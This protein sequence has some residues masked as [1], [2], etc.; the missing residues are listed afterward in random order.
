MVSEQQHVV[1]AARKYLIACRTRG[2]FKTKAAVA[3]DGDLLVSQRDTEAPAIVGA[4]TGPVIGIRRQ[5]MMNVYRLQALAQVELGQD[6][7]EDDRVAATRKADC[8]PPVSCCAGREKGGDPIGNLIW[9]L[10]P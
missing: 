1:G 3:V 8:E 9:K 7:Q 2:R 5:A 6:M 4:E 10:V